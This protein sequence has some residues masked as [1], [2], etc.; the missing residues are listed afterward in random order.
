[1][2]EQKYHVGLR[3]GEVGAY[4]LMPGDPFRT[5][6]IAEHLEGAEEKAWSR[7]FRTFTGHVDR[8]LVSTCSSGIGG[9]S[10]AIAVEELGELGVH[11]FL[12]VGTCGAAQPGIRLGDLVIATGAVRSEGTPDG[13]IPR[14]YPAMAS[15]QVVRACVEA[16][17]AAG[18]PHHLGVIRSVDALYSDLLPERMP[19]PHELRA[20][21]EMWARAGV[22]AN[23]MESSTLMV[24]SALRGWRAGVLLLCVDE[25]GAGEI[26]HLDPS[27]MHRM[28]D[29]A[30]DAVRRLIERDGAA[31]RQ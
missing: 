22:V 5:K 6:L 12:R 29:V 7:E 28:L 27:Y 11:T 3:Q 8:T 20:E 1:V 10:M 13:Y 16:A 19:R 24:V 15:H 26:H 31:Q 14:E 21:L 17:E 2:A 9:P 30:V 4:V 18:V 25:L 23:D